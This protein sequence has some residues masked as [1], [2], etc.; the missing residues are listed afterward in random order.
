[1]TIAKIKNLLKGNVV[2]EEVNS[3]INGKISVVKSL[4]LGTYLQVG[5]LTQSGG[6][7]YS[8]WKSTLNKVKS[9]LPEP[10]NVLILGL[11]GGSC[12]KLTRKLWPNVKIIGVDFDETIVDLGEKYLGLKETNTDAVIS[13]AYEYI[14][15]TVADKKKYNLIIIDLYVGQEFPVVFESD[16]FLDNVKKALSENGIVIFNRLY[17]DEKRP[18]AMRF[19]QKLEKIFT[20]VD[21]FYPQANVMFICVK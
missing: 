10:K 13:D 17:S 1:M 19:G 21:Y 14:E 15:K 5:N 16:A 8:I 6:V 3:P 18:Q 2:L 12:A 11:G 7:V 4:G 9:L 20:K